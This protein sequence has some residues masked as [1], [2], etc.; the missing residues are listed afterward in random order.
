MSDEIRPL[1]SLTL[2]LPALLRLGGVV[3]AFEK[4]SSTEDHFPRSFL[5]ED[6]KERL[7]RLRSPLSQA[8][9]VAGRAALH[10]AGRALGYDVRAVRI[11]TDRR[12][13][14]PHFDALQPCFN[15]SITHTRGLACCVASRNCA[16]GCDCERWDRTIDKEE[17]SYFFGTK[18]L[19]NRE[20]LIAWTKLEALIKL[21]GEN[22]ADKVDRS[23]QLR[24]SAIVKRQEGHMSVS[25][26]DINSEFVFSFCVENRS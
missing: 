7:S 4:W 19:T 8:E 10:R 15:F 11:A 3:V 2:Q 5:G 16:V 25:A 9:F 17:L 14:K 24:S 12:S 1:P 13:G 23:G 21:S 22:L 20:C 6:D 18:F 26:F